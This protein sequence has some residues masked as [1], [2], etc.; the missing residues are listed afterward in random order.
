MLLL[1]LRLVVIAGFK[2]GRAM[3]DEAGQLQLR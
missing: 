3:Q 2:A 1:P